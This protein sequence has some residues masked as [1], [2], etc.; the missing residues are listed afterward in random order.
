[1]PILSQ[2]YGIIIKMYFQQAE[3]NPPHIHAEYGDFVAEFNIRTGRIIEG[4]IPPKAA[5]LVREWLA[6][7]RT[8]LLAI[9]D[10]QDF[11]KITP[12]E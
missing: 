8:E 11:K 2:F 3:H 6:L 9:W 7:H 4:R 5:S 10:T 12:L 1:M